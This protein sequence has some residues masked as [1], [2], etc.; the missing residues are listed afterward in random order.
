MATGQRKHTKQIVEKYPE[1]RC[2]SYGFGAERQ[3]HLFKAPT[4]QAWHASEP[5]QDVHLD[6][7]GGAVNV[8]NTFIDDWVVIE[9]S[10]ETAEPIIFRSMP[11]KLDWGT[12]QAYPVEGEGKP[13]FSP[14]GERTCQVD[15]RTTSPG[16]S[17]IASGAES[18]SSLSSP[19]SSDR[20]LRSL[21]EEVQ[22][23]NTFIH[24]KSSSMPVDDRAVQSMPHGMFRQC[25]REESK[26]QWV[27]PASPVV[28]APPTEGQ[29]ALAG[30][31]VFFP[32]MLVVIEGL[33]KLPAFNGLIG[34]VQSLD[35]DSGRYELLLASREHQKA[36][37]KGENLRL[38]LPPPPSHAASA[39]VF[40]DCD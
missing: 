38:A 23:R 3:L 12:V 30:A 27:A 33:T 34:V 7:A 39:F 17:T 20:E 2:E 21:P 36:K 11:P 31:Q 25:L 22:V 29:S 8:K 32:G 1:L 24:L 13:E 35:G 16:R 4:G 40:N 28:S 18:N 6:A 14:I 19:E 5:S 37:V 9:G 10:G 26:N 15:S